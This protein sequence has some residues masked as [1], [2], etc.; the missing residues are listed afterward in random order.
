MRWGE[1]KWEEKSLKGSVRRRKSSTD[2]EIKRDRE[3]E[4][5]TDPF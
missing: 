4:R 2:A 3:G 1:E 5:R